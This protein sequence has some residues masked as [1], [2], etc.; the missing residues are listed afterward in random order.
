MPSAE[1]N[2]NRRE[3]EGQVAAARTPK[4]IHVLVRTT[5]MHRKYHKQYMRTKRYAVH[6]EKG[7]AQ[8]GDKVRFVECRPISKTK[9]WRLVKVL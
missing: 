7:A 8:V 9:R 2:P 3:F 6:D 5:K 1:N 4:T